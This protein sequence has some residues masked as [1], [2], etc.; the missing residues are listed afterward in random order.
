M[1]LACDELASAGVPAPSHPTS[2]RRAGTGALMLGAL[3]VV[4]GDIG[5]S[6]LYAIH[7]VFSREAARPVPI[8]PDDVFGVI[9]LVFWAI[10]IIVTVKYVMLIMRADNDGQGGI[11]ALIALLLRL[12]GP[13][14]PSRRTVVARC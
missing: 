7:T 4:F 2:G 6:P 8:N 12:R 14:T 13:T 10:T 11:M 9:S 3:G 5:T 1:P